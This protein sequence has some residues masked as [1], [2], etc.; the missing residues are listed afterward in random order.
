MKI[1]CRNSGA[2][3]SWT[4][5]MKFNSFLFFIL[6]GIKALGQEVVISPGTG[7]TGTGGTITIYGSITNNGSFTNSNVF[8]PGSSHIVGGDSASAFND[9]FISAGATVTLVTP[10]QTLSGILYCDGTLY[11]DGNLTLLSTESATA[12][13]D[14]K[15]TGDILGNVTMQRYLN[16]GFGYKYISSPFNNATIN[17]LG[18]DIDLTYWF[19]TLY[20]YDESR[21]TSGWVNYTNPDG[22]MSPLHGYAA[23]FG[24][25]SEAKTFDITGVVNNGDLSITFYNHDNL[26]TKGFNLSGNPYPSPIDWDSPSG[27]TRINIDDAIYYF[28]ASTTDSYGGTYS[29]Y[30]DGIS[31]DGVAT[32]IIPSM[33]GFF[34]HVSDGTY[35]VTGTFSMTNEVRITDREQPFIKSGSKG[36]KPFLRLEAGYSDDP[37]SFD[38]LVIYFDIKATGNFDGQ[39]DALKLYNTDYSV[40]NFYSFG[41][42]GSRLSINALPFTDEELLTVRLGIRTES[43]GEVIFRI[44]DIEGDFYYRE[45]SISDLV[46]GTEQDLLNGNTYKVTLPAGHYQERFYLN[47]ANTPTA[48]PAPAAQADDVS[49][50][51]YHGILKAK[52]NLPWFRNGMLTIFNLSGQMLYKYPINSPGEYELHPALRDGLY[53]VSFTTETR[54]ISKKLFFQG[55]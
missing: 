50:Y 22:L 40:T 20:R 44:R 1:I 43:D 8:F 11:S 48:I 9:I 38:P 45:I 10:G 3:Y 24:E 31:S 26:Y 2:E 33:Q 42:D 5:I 7:M 14:G 13:I 4:S 46:T 30:M 54:K 23:N 12:L 55:R 15:G 27:W 17:E 34:I 19:P 18:D 32:S 49:I 29:T 16:S 51:T 47:L 53:I 35:P 37:L 36:S 39:Y 21:T 41:S 28:M 25:S 6:L 52:I